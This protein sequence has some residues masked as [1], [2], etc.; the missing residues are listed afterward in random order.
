MATER[1]RFSRASQPFGARC[2]LYGDLMESWK[3]I[4]T[5]NISAVGMRFRSAM[6][7]DPGAKLEIEIDLPALH[8]PLV[9]HAQVVWSETIASSVTENGIEFI[10]LAPE[11]EERIDDLVKFLVG[12]QPPASHS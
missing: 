3:T 12:N 7:F 5:V 6:L 9:L 8:E 2:R 1:R 10:D 11:L 4:R